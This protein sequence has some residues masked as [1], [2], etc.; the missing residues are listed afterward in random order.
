[1]P[2]LAP[3]KA[4]ILICAAASEYTAVL[5]LYY[6]CMVCIQWR[7]LDLDLVQLYVPVSIRA[8]MA[9]MR[10]NHPVDLYLWVTTIYRSIRILQKVIVTTA[11]VIYR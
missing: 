9:I 8:S 11:V 5:R 6:E 10:V 3:S 2:L 1:M 4:L 7:H